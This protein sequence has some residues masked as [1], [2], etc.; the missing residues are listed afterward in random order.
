[1]D[2]NVWGLLFMAGFFAAIGGFL[3]WYCY[4]A[5]EKGEKK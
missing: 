3:I 1:M 2:E 5:K 4:P